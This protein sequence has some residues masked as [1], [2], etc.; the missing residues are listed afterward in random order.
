MGKRFVRGALGDPRRSTRIPLAHGGA[1]ALALLVLT[2]AALA[3]AGAATAALQKPTYKAGDGWVYILQGTLGALPGF[4]ASQTGT[5]ELA[6]TGLVDVSVVGPAATTVNGASVAATEVDTHTSG[7][8]NGTFTVPGN[9]T[10]GVSGTFSSDGTEF[11]EDA[12]YL[13]VA[14]N[15]SASYVVDVTTIL[16]VRVTADFWVNATTAYASVP[17]FDLNV[18]D[19]ASAPFTSEVFAKTSVSGF[20]PTQILQNRTTV[21]ATWTRHVL[22]LDTI[23]VEAGTF[24]AYRLNESLGDFPGLATVVPTAGANASGWFSNDVGYYVKRTAYVNGTPDAE[25]RLK[26]Y[27]Y[28]VPGG[29]SALDLGLLL[30]VPVAVV[31]AI[32]WLVLR[33]RKTRSAPTNPP[34]P[35]PFTRMPPKEPGGGP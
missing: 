2:A 6:L 23:S 11:W 27:T 34:A 19:S 3:S 25:M 7:Y 29:L 24:S 13:P 33:R 10:I 1:L 20:G 28:A 9:V 15:T 22:S 16:P 21:A 8:L 26:S 4:N 18:G 12:A 14:S 35:P 5:F 30:V 17:A 31:V 32:L